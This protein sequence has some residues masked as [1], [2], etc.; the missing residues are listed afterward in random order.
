MTEFFSSKHWAIKA[1][2]WATQSTGEIEEGGGFS[3][4]YYAQQAQIAAE[5][6]D[7]PLPTSSD[8][9]K[10]LITDGSKSFWGHDNSK[11]N[12]LTF[13]ATPTANSQNPVSSTGIKAAIDSAKNTCLNTISSN[14]LYVT[15]YISG[16]NW[17]REWFSNSAKTTRVWLEQGGYNAGGNEYTTQ[18]VTF[19]KSFSNTNYSVLLGECG[20]YRS[21]N[22]VVKNR[23]Q[24]TMDLYQGAG[25]GGTITSQFW[26]VCGK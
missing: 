24:T 8:S 22:P 23:T 6:I 10:S 5:T 12:V 4:K 26:M 7:F 19:L 25:S 14:G 2:K 11:Q 20:G 21:Y 13:D 18:T 9:G 1:K 3:A 15:T 17:Y 16:T